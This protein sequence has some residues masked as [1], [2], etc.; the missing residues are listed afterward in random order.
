M[1]QLRGDVYVSP[2]DYGFMVYDVSEG[3]GSSASWGNF[4]SFPEALKC[5]RKVAREMIARFDESA[6]RAQNRRN[7][8]TVIEGGR[9]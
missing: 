4:T 3:G 7:S 9:E 6:A 5:A 8:F 1:K 2:T